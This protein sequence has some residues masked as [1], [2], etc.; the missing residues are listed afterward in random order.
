MR[1]RVSS[2][3]I[4]IWIGGVIIALILAFLLGPFYIFLTKDLKISPVRT[5][6]FS[7]GLRKVNNQVNVL[8]LGI[9]GGSH[10]GPLLS[11]SMIVLNYDFIKK[12]AVTI[13]MPRDVWSATLQDRLNSAYAY[14]EAKKPGGGLAL[15]KAEVGAIVGIPIQY[16]VV[17]NFNEFKDIIDYFGGIEVDVQNSFV[18]KKFPLE[19]K[20]AD[21]CGGKDEEFLCRYETI[22]FGKGRQHMD[23]DT[24]LKFVRSRNAEGKEGS[25]FARS[26]RQ[27]QVTEAI[28]GKV[29]KTILSLN[30]GKIKEMY[31]VLDKSVQRDINNQ[32]TASLG[33]NFILSPKFYQKNFG[34]PRE[35]FTIPDGSL[36]E[37]R[38]VLV[39]REDFK[40]IHKY[41]GCLLEKE[42][43][44]K[45][46]YL[47]ED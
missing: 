37:G 19:G 32:Q 9:P 28:K 8:I 39:P 15:A 33:K 31:S 41:V 26:L 12:R 6:L 25:D 14:G 17:M 3:K 13:G 38:Y 11:D 34:L 23:G 7:G 43:E 2:N 46:D 22:R 4:K 42:D 1:D 47:K 20:E 35:L 21:D 10:D 30:L 24:A 27:Q 40:S 36:Y 44:G 5:L 29:V 18:D 16:V 45:C